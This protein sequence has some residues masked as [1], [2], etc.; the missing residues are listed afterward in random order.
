VAVK[1]EADGTASVKGNGMA[2]VQTSGML[3]LK[4]SLTMIN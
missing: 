2:E 4:G 3:T 1:V